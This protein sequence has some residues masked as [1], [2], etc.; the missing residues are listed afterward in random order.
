VSD[1]I[2]EF[3]KS[4]VTR[5]IISTLR[6][7]IPMPPQLERAGGAWPHQP[8]SGRT[9]IVGAAAAG[10]GVLPTVLQTLQGMGADIATL[11]GSDAGAIQAAA[12]SLNCTLQPHGDGEDAPKVHALVFDA[13]GIGDVAG[14]RALYDFFHARAG[15]IGGSGRSVIVA[16]PPEAAGSPVQ[17]AVNRAVEGFNRSL[18]KELG[19]KGIT[20]QVLYVAPG[21]DERLAGP[22]R[23]FLSP[24]SAYVSGQVLRV[25]ALATTQ[26]QPRW[27]A[28]LEGRVALVT[29][30]AHGIGAAIAETLAREGARVVCLD[31]PAE[32]EH[33][34]QVAEKIGGSVLAADITDAEAPRR[35]ADALQQDFGGVDIV[36]HNAGVTRDKTLARMSPEWWDMT[37]DINLAAIVRINELLLK[38]GIIRRD[39]R[40][41][42]L[43]SISGIGGNAGQTNYSCSKAGLIGYVAALS[44]EVAGQ[45]ITVNAVAPGFIETQMTAAIPFAIREV[46]R[47]LNSLS[48]GGLPQDVAEVITF[49]A[50]PGAVGVSGTTLRVCGQSLVGA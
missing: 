19:R 6:L 15:K 38:E 49:M 3:T 42:C 32:E 2:L 48:Q 47:R 5:K 23:F 28:P 22:L 9:V 18:A 39:G 33:L 10:K 7:P 11:A 36:V 29:G 44:R 31:R 46:G 41:V 37:L 1:F 34:K 4:P 50:S 26:A 40:I 24:N 27:T 8:L 43:S 30:A 14:L 16:R 20:A 35:I 45:G 17:A 12:A 21:A 13:T 25:S